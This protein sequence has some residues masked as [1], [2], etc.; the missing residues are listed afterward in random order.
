MPKLDPMSLFQI[1]DDG[2][3]TDDDEDFTGSSMIKSK[4]HVTTSNHIS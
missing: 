3:P 1:D 4:P 2:P